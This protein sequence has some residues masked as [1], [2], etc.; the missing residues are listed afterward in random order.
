MTTTTIR[1]TAAALIAAGAVAPVALAGGEPKNEWPFTRSVADRATAQVEQSHSAQVSVVAGEPKNQWP[2]TR[3]VAGRAPSQVHESS[4]V[5]R[6]GYGEAKNEQPFTQPTFAPTVIIRTNGG[7]DW[8]D[9]GIGAG[10]T[11]GLVIAALGAATLRA[12][13]GRRPRMT[14]A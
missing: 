8:G 14:G 7:F 13:H 6:A 4:S 5:T 9:A 11:L 2:F 1:V 10:A 12:P 3:P